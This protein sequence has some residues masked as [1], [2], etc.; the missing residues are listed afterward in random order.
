MYWDRRTELNNIVYISVPS[1]QLLIVVLPCLAPF[2]RRKAD[3]NIPVTMQLIVSQMNT[4]PFATPAFDFLNMRMDGMRSLRS[5]RSLC[6]EKSHSYSRP[7]MLRCCGLLFCQVP[8][9]A[10]GGEN[11]SECVSGRGVVQLGAKSCRLVGRKLQKVE[12]S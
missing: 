9:S 12:L 5:I 1:V 7:R 4:L 6:I 3:E 10:R 8:Q 2:V 11:C